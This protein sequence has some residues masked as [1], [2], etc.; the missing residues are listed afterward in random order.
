MRQR[1][2]MLNQNIP[3]NMNKKTATP[4][5]DPLTGESFI[6]KSSNQKFA[7]L[8]NKIEFN[9][10]KAKLRRNENISTKQELD[11]NFKILQRILGPNKVVTKS[12]EYLLGAEFIFGVF[13]HLRTINNLNYYCVFNYGYRTEDKITYQIIKIQ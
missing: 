3:P 10:A 7:S 13:T 5:N 11:N 9:N 4:K 1:Q 12:K 6:P 2:S 8:A